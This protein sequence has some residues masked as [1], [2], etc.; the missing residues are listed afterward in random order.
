MTDF[1]IQALRSAGGYRDRTSLIVRW[2]AFGTS[3]HNSIDNE[4]CPDFSSCIP[5]LYTESEI[6][7]RTTASKVNNGWNGGESDPPA[8]TLSEGE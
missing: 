1:Y 6:E 2:W 7:R 5:D 3:V 8:A 4:C